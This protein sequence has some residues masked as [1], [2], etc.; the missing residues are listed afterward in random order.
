MSVLPKK[1]KSA[2]NIFCEEM[3]PVVRNEVLSN[4]K[5]LF[6]VLGE[7]WTALKQNDYEKFMH[8]Y[9]RAHEDKERYKREQDNFTSTKVYT[10]RIEN[11]MDKKFVEMLNSLDGGGYIARMIFSWCDLSDVF[12]G[13]VTFKTIEKKASEAFTGEIVVL[14]NTKKETHF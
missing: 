5:R 9:Q 10:D 8:Y 3:G 2:Y 6:T 7:K 13:K 11:A 12:K 4:S 14:K 1:N